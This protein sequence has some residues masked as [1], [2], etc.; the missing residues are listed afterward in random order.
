MDADSLAKNTPNTRLFKR[1]C[2]FLWAFAVVLVRHMTATTAAITL[3]CMFVEMLF[4]ILAACL[5]L[6]SG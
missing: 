4:Y 1:G 6:K 5:V 3:A 2:L